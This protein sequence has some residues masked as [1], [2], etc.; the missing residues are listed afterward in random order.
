MNAS[1]ETRAAHSVPLSGIRAR[2]LASVAET[3]GRHT[4]TLKEIKSIRDWIREKI[5][6]PAE[7]YRSY[8][9]DASRR[10]I[11][12]GYARIYGS[13]T[14][15]R[16]QTRAFSARGGKMAGKDYGDLYYTFA[17]RFNAYI[18]VYVYA[19]AC[20]W[21]V[22]TRNPPGNGL[23]KSPG[24]LTHPCANTGR[25]R[26]RRRCTYKTRRAFP[27]INAAAAAG[28]ISAFRIKAKT[29]PLRLYPCAYSDPREPCPATALCVRTSASYPSYNRSKCET[30]R[31]PAAR[32]RIAYRRTGS[33]GSR[34]EGQSSPCLGAPRNWLKHEKFVELKKASM[35][36]YVH[37]AVSA[38][39]VNFVVHNSH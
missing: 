21:Y 2:S 5:G 8:N 14:N 33:A 27:T 34:G 25:I 19:R 39:I 9:A 11:I 32:R 12:Y 7:T 24:V 1:T 37:G 38:S 13:R 17:A 35:T 6:I 20:G 23:G 36:T 4:Y 10:R 30:R 31:S 16:L 18:R 15:A 28:E 26:T 3:V 29:F 22:R